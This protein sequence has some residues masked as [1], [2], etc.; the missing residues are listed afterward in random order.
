MK[1]LDIAKP[2]VFFDGMCN[3]CSSSVQFIIRHD[4]KK[5]FLFAPLQSELGQEAIKQF[6]GVAP[7]SVILYKDG[8]FYSKSDA[9]LHIARILDG[10]WKM[11]YAGIILPRI[12]RNAMYNFMAYNRYRWWGKKDSCMIP[13][14]EIR[15]RFIL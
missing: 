8:K 10:G 5:Q 12:I 7:D 15:S 3:F 11:C 13:A 6:P 1:I 2:V 4:K 9:T 14:P